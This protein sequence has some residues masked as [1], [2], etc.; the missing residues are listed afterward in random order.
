MTT[1]AWDGTTLA[2]DSLGDQNGLRMVITKLHRGV[3]ADGTPFIMGAAGESSWA[4]MTHAWIKSLSLPDMGH[5]TYPHQV[6]EGP[7]RNDPQVILVLGKHGTFY[8]VGKCLT[9]L[10]SQFHAV[11]SGRDF[12]IAA[13]HLGKSA[14]EAVAVAIKFDCY[15]GGEIRT[16][17]LTK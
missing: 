15:S 7:E 16:M 9:R 17:R 14:E 12:A 2:S 13:M 5:A 4:N 11:G 8:K 3:L 6:N 1:I 10:E